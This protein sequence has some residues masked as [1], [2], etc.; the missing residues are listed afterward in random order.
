MN[1]RENIRKQRFREIQK[2]REEGELNIRYAS[3]DPL[4]HNQVRILEADIEK[5]RR[6]IARSRLNHSF[7]EPEN[8]SEPTRRTSIIKPMLFMD[9]FFLGIDGLWVVVPDGRS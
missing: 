1:I 5:G 3:E 7:P 4:L 8:V 2:K 6:S 9:I